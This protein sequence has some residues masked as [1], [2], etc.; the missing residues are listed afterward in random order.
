MRS[1]SVS[2]SLT[3]TSIKVLGELAINILQYSYTN[4]E[5]LSHNTVQFVVK[6]SEQLAL[7]S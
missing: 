3:V 5:I 6:R 1:S 4:M 7:F 2:C